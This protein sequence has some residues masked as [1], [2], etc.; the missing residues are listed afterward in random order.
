[1]LISLQSQSLVGLNFKFNLTPMFCKLVTKLRVL[2]QAV[3]R[4]SVRQASLG[5]E[6]QK[7]GEDGIERGRGHVPAPVT[8]ELGSSE[9][10]LALELRIK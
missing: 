5:S 2:K 3:Y 4:A 10:D 7:A 1:M 9:Q 6:R 8:A